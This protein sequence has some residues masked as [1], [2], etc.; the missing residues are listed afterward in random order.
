MPDFILNPFRLRLE[1]VS[2]L[3]L[4]LFHSVF[5]I[6]IVFPE[7]K[8]NVEYRM[9]NVERRSLPSFPLFSPRLAAAGIF[10]YIDPT[11]RTS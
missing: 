2:F 11:A 10:R 5:D 1:G 3:R 7:R 4:T 9:P 8:S 6:D